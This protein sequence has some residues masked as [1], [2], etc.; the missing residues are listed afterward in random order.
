MNKGI[1]IVLLL[2]LT[3]G[4]AAEDLIKSLQKGLF[5]E[6]ANQNLEAAIKA[7]QSVVSQAEEP[8]KIM[9]TALFRLGECYRKQGQTNLAAEQ[10]QRILNNFQDHT[11]LTLL[12]QQQLAALGVLDVM[13]PLTDKA[14]LLQPDEAKELRRVQIL[15]KTSPDLAGQELAN[16]AASGYLQVVRWLLEQKVA[17]L[18]GLNSA[19]YN[20]VESGHMAIAELLLNSGAEVNFLFSTR[21]ETILNRAVKKGFHNL[22]Q[23]LLKNKANP[24]AYPVNYG[25]S[26]LATPLFSAIY[27]SAEMTRLL[28]QNGADPNARDSDGYT[29]FGRACQTG[30]EDLVRLFLAHKAEINPV[31]SA[32]TPLYITVQ[33]GNTNLTRMLLNHGADPYLV[34][35]NWGAFV[36][37]R[38]G[39]ADSERATELGQMLLERAPATHTPALEYELESTLLWA[40]RGNNEAI[41]QRLLELGVN[42]DAWP[43]G[44]LGS[45]LSSVITSHLVQISLANQSAPTGGSRTSADSR[46]NYLPMLKLLLNHGADPNIRNH[47]N[48]TSLG[49]LIY[50]VHSRGITVPG[51]W[52]PAI[53]PPLLVDSI[54]LLLEHG[55]EVNMDHSSR[56][57][58]IEYV[59]KTWPDSAQ[60]VRALDLLHKHGADISAGRRNRVEVLGGSYPVF[61]NYTNVW[62]QRSL[63]EALYEA[64][65]EE[66]FAQYSKSDFTRIKIRR[67]NG[68]NEEII[69]YDLT[70]VIESTNCSKNCW[71]QGGDVIE[72]PTV[73]LNLAV[74]WSHEEL[75][76]VLRN[77]LKREITLVGP[78]TNSVTFIEGRLQNVLVNSRQRLN[79]EDL[80]RVQVIRIDPQTGQKHQAIFDATAN[81]EVWLQDGDIVEVPAKIP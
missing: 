42:V 21:Q 50:N 79:N 18:S 67:I 1:L 12:S 53:I 20:A 77:C 11:N 74:R 59:A 14:N 71:L 5:E 58:P 7:Y 39:K 66:R 19:L 62:R 72:I 75:F 38:N 36:A 63:L 52:S 49:Q 40:V 47:Q 33:D 43:S 32:F 9:A 13:N 22:A 41:V 15:V 57:S 45:P 69:P 48:L 16:A 3:L 29:A 78:N 2:S 60:K 6:E 55:A 54:Q 10:Y 31:S 27:V 17:T 64:Y 34:K 68:E 35:T 23:F 70:P 56:L 4:Q 44:E 26:L 46:Q 25:R 51:L 8:R 81:P 61:G 73:E 37:L 80:K 24:N 28:L 76:A 30:N 65:S